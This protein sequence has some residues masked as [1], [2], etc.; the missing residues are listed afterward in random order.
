M[1]VVRSLLIFL[2]K[3]E[4]TL[5]GPTSRKFKLPLETMLFIVSNHKTGF[6]ID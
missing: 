6:L 3:P 5:P 4:S 1:L 2:F